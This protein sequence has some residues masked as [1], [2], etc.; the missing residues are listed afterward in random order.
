MSALG[1]GKLSTPG[2]Q[3]KTA[4]DAGDA[5]I[6]SLPL[7]RVLGRKHCIRWFKGY[8]RKVMEPHRAS[9]PA[10]C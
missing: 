3:Y 6:T 8:K 5:V 7:Q 9:G 1:I 10:V 4:F 2:A